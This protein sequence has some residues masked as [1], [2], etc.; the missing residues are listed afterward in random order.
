MHP[1]LLLSCLAFA[2]GALTPLAAAQSPEPPCQ[3]P[4]AAQL[5]FWLGA[6]DLAWTNDDG[7]GQ[8]TNTITKALDRCVVH[9]RFESA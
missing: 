6:W 2:F 5:D 1:R 4:E 3:S 7:E 9:E 8:G